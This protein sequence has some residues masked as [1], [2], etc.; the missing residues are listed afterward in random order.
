MRQASTISRR[1]LVSSFYN[2]IIVTMRPRQW[3]KN[4][5][6]VLPGIVFDAQLGN[7][8]ALLSVVVTI[9]LLSLVSG[10]VYIFNDIIDY[11]RD[12]LHPVKRNRPIP[13]GRLRVLPALM[14][15]GIIFVATIAFSVVWKPALALVLV[16]YFTAQVSYSIWFKHMPIIDILVI[17][18][19]FVL[20]I[21]AGVVV[22]EVQDFSSWLYVC[23]GLLALFLAIG[24]RRQELISLGTDAISTRPVFRDYSLPMLDDMLRMITTATLVTYI[25]YTIEVPVR[26][27]F[28]INL[29]LLTLPFVIYGLF[30]YLYLMH[31]KGDGGAP[32][33]VLLGDRPLQIAILSWG[34]A[35]FTLIYVLPK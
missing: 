22:I 25:V 15:A 14:S 23:G 21:L 33:E 18:S 17:T 19:G 20:R 4:V 11:K 29:A 6:F 5:L 12:T 9:L 7:P 1:S 16:L 8:D 31:V 35:F 10:S 24:K 26:S 13:S 30:R 2:E 3:T 28:D 27:V 32:E 34:L